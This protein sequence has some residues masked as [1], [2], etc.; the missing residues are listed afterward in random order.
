MLPFPPPTAQD[1]AG[2]SFGVGIVQTGTGVGVG[3]GGIVGAMVGGGVTT[4]GGVG[5]TLAQLKLFVAAPL[6]PVE[7]MACTHQS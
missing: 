5:A 3:V 2:G 1:G 4:G 6:Q 7:F